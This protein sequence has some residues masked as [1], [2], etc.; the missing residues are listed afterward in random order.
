MCCVVVLCVHHPLCCVVDLCVHLPLCRVVVL[1]V[2]DPMCCVVVLYVHVPMC[3]VVVL[4][5]HVPL[6]CVVVLYVH[7]PLCCVVVLYVHVPMCFV[8]VLCVRVR[9][10]GAGKDGGGG[11]ISTQCQQ[12]RDSGEDAVLLPR[13]H[14]ALTGSGLG[15]DA[16]KMTSPP[17]FLFIKTTQTLHSKGPKQPL[18][19]GELKG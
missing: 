4:Y 19:H 5:I 11:G 7:V 2:H 3:C 9:M 14:S 8:A 1:Y 16:G 6:R 15:G 12:W 10:A 17:L 18:S 13:S